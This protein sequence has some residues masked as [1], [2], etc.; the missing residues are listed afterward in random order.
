MNVKLTLLEKKVT[1]SNQGSSRQFQSESSHKSGNAPR[2]LRDLLRTRTLS[3]HRNCED[4]VRSHADLRTREGYYRFLVAKLRTYE[5]FADALN[6]SSALANLPERCSAIQRA[7]HSDLGQLYHFESVSS[8]NN[9]DYKSLTPSIQESQAWGVGYVFEGSAAG[10]TVL[11]KTVFQTL[12][13]P[14]I[15]FLNLL[16]SERAQR[17][18]GF[19]ASLER[20]Q[21]DKHHQLMTVQFAQEVFGFLSNSVSVQNKV[22]VKPLL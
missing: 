5:K 22:F 2:S 11:R 7:L 21:L 17:W 19:V 20:S 15:D 14:P 1:T 9:V 4:V 18:R 10:A 3:H 13:D 12:P 16:I 6:A 8:G